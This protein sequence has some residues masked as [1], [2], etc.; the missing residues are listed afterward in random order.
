[1]EL[2]LGCSTVREGG[3]RPIGIW[4]DLAGTG[5][6]TVQ[7]DGFLLLFACARGFRR[8]RIFEYSGAL[9]NMQIFISFARPKNLCKKLVVC[10]ND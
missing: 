7:M 10:G 3:V 1:M 2:C 6:N 9:S 4:R 5:S 8:R